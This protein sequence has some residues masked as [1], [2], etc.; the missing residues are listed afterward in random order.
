MKKHFSYF[1]AAICALGITLLASCGSGNDPK[2]NNWTDVNSKA[3][4][5]LQIIDSICGAQG[6]DK[7]ILQEASG[8]PLNTTFNLGK[9]RGIRSII[10]CVNSAKYDVTSVSDW[11][12]S[13]HDIF[14]VDNQSSKGY[15]TPQ[16]MGYAYLNVSYLDGL[17]SAN[18]KVNVSNAALKSISLSTGRANNQIAAGEKIQLIVEG[19]YTD[20][21]TGIINN[22]LLKADSESIIKVDNQYITGLKTGN[23][24]LRTTYDSYNASVNVEVTPSKIVGIVMDKNNPQIFTTGIPQ[25]YQFKANLLLSDGSILNIPA[26]TI[27]SPSITQCKLQRAPDDAKIPFISTGNGC[28]INS[29][30]ESGENRIIYSYSILDQNRKI[31][32]TFESSAIIKSTD[33]AI[34]N[35]S[36]NLDQ[37]LQNGGM[38]VGNI[39]RY[40]IYANLTNGSKI[41]ITKSL[42]LNAHLYYQNADLS[43][44][45][46][47]GDTGYIG[48]VS[49][50][51]DDGKGGLI[52]LTDYLTKDDTS[53]KSARLV[54]NASLTKFSVKFDKDILVMPNVISVPQLSSYFASNIYPK[55]NSIDKRNFNTF[56]G[57]DS[58]G[59]PL[60]TNY[61]AAITKFKDNQ[62][63]AS[64]LND[65]NQTLSFKQLPSGTVDVM[66]DSTIPRI[67]KIYGSDD[68]SMTIVTIG[69]NNRSEPQTITTSNINKQISNTHSISRSFTLGL[70][71]SIEL[72]ATFLDIVGAKT[73]TKISTS[74]NRTW[75]DSST[76]AQTYTLASQNVPLNAFG[77]AIV[78]QKVFKTNIGFTGKFN[79]PLTD[80]SCVPFTINGEVSGFNL[81]SPA[82]TKY[83]N[84]IN[85][86][87][88][89]IFNRL[90]NGENSM[91][92]FA[93]YTSDTATTDAKTNTVAIYA[94]YPGD[95][96]YDSID[97][98]TQTLNSSSQKNAITLNKNIVN[99]NSKSIILSQKN[100]IKTQ[101]S[102]N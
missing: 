48:S 1:N 52:K 101:V 17:Y 57:F 29:T 90:F 4:S 26:S 37:D 68:P 32:Q 45:I 88:D 13:D 15:I 30:I 99:R 47:T 92:F 50:G 9:S 67:N 23:T 2:T 10:Q 86:P 25:S 87:D 58:N 65:K 94:Y 84:I 82:C 95:P 53:N 21:S 24:T 19:K 98:G 78:V 46:I 72:D 40:H 18:Y 73:T 71:Q 39:Y 51:V 14:T 8:E 12:S 56:S 60:L 64:M 49:A 36:L 28:N 41:D 93:N 43:Q 34:N 59:N 76:E 80:N 91:T 77:K 96:G 81:Y 54:L 27:S 22:A 20:G 55:L 100:L 33:A 75:S 102:N 16:D 69:C 61:S 62:L 35:I 79:L 3:T 70:E 5:Q 63:R 44:K 66:I 38:L 7:F 83:S 42:P 89:P 6:I 31:I 85:K 11:S 97:C 74:A